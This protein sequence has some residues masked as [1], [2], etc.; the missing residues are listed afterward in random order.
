MTRR[1]VM[2]C[3]KNIGGS[4]IDL[5]PFTILRSGRSRVVSNRTNIGAMPPTKSFEEGG[6]SRFGYD[7]RV[8]NINPQMYGAEGR[9]AY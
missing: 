6:N 5:K 3:F 4:K 2:P 1:R 7:G 9:C 8:P